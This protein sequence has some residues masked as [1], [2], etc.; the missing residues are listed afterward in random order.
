MLYQDNLQLAARPFGD[1]DQILGVAL[2]HDHGTQACPVSSKHLFA[3][4][5]NREHPTTQGNLPGHPH[6]LV[7][8]ATGEGRNQSRS[9]IKALKGIDVDTGAVDINLYRDD[10]T[11]IG[12]HPIVRKTDIS[13]EVNDK[14][15]ILV[16]DVL[17]TGRTI[18]SALDA[19]VDFGRP[20]RIQLAV[21]IDRGLRELPI[22][23]NYTGKYIQTSPDESVNVLL[24]ECDGVDR[25][26]LVSG[27]ANG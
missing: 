15:I 27:E 19:L 17:Y 25:V 7:Y 12:H 6:F 9:R 10:W 23:A 22:R 8:F 1:V 20:S 24:T 21:V 4:A 26:D 5:A 16:D 2:G 11:R 14:N 3:N 13:F 18:R